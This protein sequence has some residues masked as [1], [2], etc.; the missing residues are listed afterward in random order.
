MLDSAT[1]TD[2][3]IV[4]PKGPGQAIVEVKTED[5]DAFKTLF[6]FYHDELHFSPSEFIGKTVGDGHEIRYRRDLAYI[7]SP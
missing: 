3:Q 6:G 7:Q 2:A 1:I 5:C 4:F